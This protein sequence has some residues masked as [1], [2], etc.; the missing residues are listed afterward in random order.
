MA[1]LVVVKTHVSGRYTAYT[2]N[3]TANDSRKSVE[4]GIHS[5][6]DIGKNTT[7]TSREPD[8]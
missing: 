3:E 4:L 8:T 5:G 6:K 7:N 1:N 2:A